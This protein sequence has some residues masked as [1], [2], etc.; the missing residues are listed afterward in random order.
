MARD[1][2]VGGSTPKRLGDAIVVAPQRLMMTDRGE[3]PDLEAVFDVVDGELR[4]VQVIVTA[5][6]AGREVKRADLRD[7]P[8]NDLREHA[9]KAWTLRPAVTVGD[10]VWSADLPEGGDDDQRAV[11]NLRA[12]RKRVDDETL[13]RVAR[14]YSDSPDRPTAA[15]AEAFQL[16]PRQAGNYVRRAR[17]AGFLPP[18]TRGSSDG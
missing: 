1:P 12:T 11:R 3:E 18:F 5:S 14:I 13:R 6:L 10:R 8:I 9:A 15:V 4:C 7:I 2:M 17:D 16:Q